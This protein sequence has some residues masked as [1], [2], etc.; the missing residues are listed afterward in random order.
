MKKKLLLVLAVVALLGLGAYVSLPSEQA[1]FHPSVALLGHPAPAIDVTSEREISTGRVVGFADSYNTYGWLNIPYAAPP[2]DTLRWRAPQTAPAWEGVRHANRYGTPCLQYWGMLAGVEG[3]PGDVVGSEDCLS[4]NIWAPRE[5]DHTRQKPVMVWIHGGGNDS[6]TANL[7]QAHHLSGREDVVVV[8]VN[9][10]LSLLG[11]LSHEAIRATAV[12]R[13]D[14]SGNFG[15]LDLIASL[16]W[17]QKNIEAFGGDPNNVTIFGE[18]AGGRNVFSLLASPRAAGLFHKAIV[19]SGSADTTLKT[20]AEDVPNLASG[21]PI[22]GLINSSKALI[23]TVLKP[24]ATALS[25]AALEDN[26]ASHSASQIMHTLRTIPADTI[27]RVASAR[28]QEEGEIRSA[29]VIRDGY[30]IPFTSTLELLENPNHYNSVPLMLG[31]NR[32]EQKLFMMSDPMFVS[33][34]F[35]L[36]PRIK[37]RQRYE[38]VAEYISE[39]WKASAVDEPAKRIVRHADAPVFAYRFDWDDLPANWLADLP[40]LIGAAHGLEISFV[41]GDFTGGVALDPL[42]TS[43]NAAGRKALSLAMMDYWGQFAHTG[44]PD[45]G[46]K[47]GLAEWRPWQISGENVMV[48]DSPASGGPRMQEIRT[49]VA[50]IKARIPIDAVLTSQKERCEAYAVLFLHGY[51]TSDFWNPTEYQAL[52]CADFPA[53][54][55]REG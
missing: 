45:R 17:V 25:E 21:E 32:D 53:L 35:G 19:Q 26:L 52:G 31:T 50:E 39:N 37:D 22:S 27:M 34:R 15:T 49:D 48:L 18:S 42:L 23:S 6:G 29:R 13:E 44:N 40:S 51:M 24:Y 41:F 14:A 16:Q 30:V 11:W 36:L 54:M 12:T 4:L 9:Y 47:G 3:K 33:N 38:R 10:R 28:L 7:Y 20:L 5:A 43:A 1:V 2:V 8:L 46:R 55:F